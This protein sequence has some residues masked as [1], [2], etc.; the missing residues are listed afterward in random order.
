MKPLFTAVGIGLTIA[1]PFLVYWAL[2]HDQAT[3]LLPLL[4]VL[5]VLRGVT[6]NRIYERMV[7]GGTL[8]GVVIIAVIWGHQL[9]LKFYP[10][11]VNFGFLIIFS[12]SLFSPPSI[13]ER[14]ARVRH[15]DLSPEGVAYTL[16][17]TWVWSGFFLINGSLAAA[18][19]LWAS[20]EVWTLYNGFIA[21]LLIGILAGGEWLVRRRIVRE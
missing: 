3:K 20:D 4:L 2:Q 7:L 5:L 18:T 10:A 19:A 13:V 11:M 9:G 17:V 15:P 6:G 12:S 8:V 14:L 21:Y 16:K 1:Y